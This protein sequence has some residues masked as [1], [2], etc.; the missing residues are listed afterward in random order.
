MVGGP[1]CQ[2]FSTAGRRDPADPRNQMTEQYLLLVEKLQPRFIVIENV[3]GF[4]MRFESD[5]GLDKLIKDPE[6]D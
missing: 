4:N 3:A 5:E 1:P 2:G 6:H